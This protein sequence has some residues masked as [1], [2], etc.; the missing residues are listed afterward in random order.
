MAINATLKI[1]NQS[2]DILHCRYGF[3][4]QIDSKSYPMGGMQGGDI[5]ISLES[6]S[7]TLLLEKMLTEEPLSVP[8]SLEFWDEQELVHVR[9]LEWS[10]AYICS[11]GEDMQSNSAVPMTMALRITPLRLDINRSIRIDRR[12]PQTYGFWWEDYKEEEQPV[13]VEESDSPTL[14]ELKW[15]DRQTKEDID[16]ILSETWAS[17]SIKLENFKAKDELRI[18]IREKNGHFINRK[19]AEVEF[20]TKAGSSSTLEIDKAFKFD[21]NIN[22]NREVEV[23]IY[24]KNESITGKTSLREKKG[25]IWGFDNHDT[26]KIKED[27]CIVFS[28]ER[29]SR[30]RSLISIDSNNSKH[31]AFISQNSISEILLDSRLN[32]DD[33]LAIE[34][35]CNTINS[36]KTHLVK[37]GRTTDI[38]TK[39][40]KL[41]IPVNELLKDVQ[42]TL[43]FFG[44]VTTETE[45]GSMSLILIDDTYPV[46]YYQYSIGKD[47]EKTKTNV[48]NPAGNSII[49]LHEVI[50]HGLSLSLGR[51]NA[52]QHEDA[53]L[54]EN[55]LLR[56]MGYDDIQRD[57]TDHGPKT[58][59]PNPQRQP[60]F[61]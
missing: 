7:D 22:Q 15:V 2:F 32:S 25:G 42:L 20:V 60:Q 33:K 4:R 55:L 59:I 17:L 51:G 50:G 58:I 54:F 19:D 43:K 41:Y 21:K 3:H 14:V 30:F 45:N 12:F 39:E 31:I 46:D 36:T 1:A 53:I 44:T 34:M 10:Q 18:V 49:T 11:V 27:I 52:N 16:V 56:I 29:F 5:F 24:W 61:K 48:P 40:I 47:G 57:G 9:T 6:T 28:G 35:I 37:F 13:F 38:L 8:G 26:N 23:V